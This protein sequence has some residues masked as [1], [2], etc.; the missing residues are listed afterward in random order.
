MPESE[1]EHK[2]EEKEEHAEETDEQETHEEEPDVDEELAEL[3]SIIDERD[4]EIERL[5]S[6]LADL[7]GRYDEH[8]ARHHAEHEQQQQ[9]GLPEPEPEP[10]ER[11]WYFKP[12]KQR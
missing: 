4:A 5:K 7:R 3:I 10:E 12:I 2:E 6:E 11:H 8:H 9:S 1:H